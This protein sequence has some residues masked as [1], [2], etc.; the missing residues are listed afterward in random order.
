MKIIYEPKSVIRSK[1]ILAGQQKAYEA[2]AEAASQQYILR[3]KNESNSNWV[4]YVYQTLPNQT[5][6]MFSLAWFASPY[7][8][9]PG[10]FIEF[11]WYTTYEFVWGNTGEVIPGVKFSA[12]G[13]KEAELREKNLTTFGIIDNAPQLTK[14]VKD[15]N[16]PGTLVIED[17]ANI[18]ALTFSVGIGMSGNGTF[19]QQAEPNLKHLFT[20]SPQYWIAAGQEVQVGKILNIQTITQTEEILFQPNVYRLQATLNSLNEWEI[21]PF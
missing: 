18:P 5:P 4:F 12:G 15:P 6:K 13:I 8:I 19:V 16:N 2:R 7:A 21:S 9:A 11:V 3:C 10:N 14:P 1:A 20:P 17:A